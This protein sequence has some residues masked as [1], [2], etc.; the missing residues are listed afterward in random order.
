M[1]DARHSPLRNELREATADTH[2]RLERR[3]LLLAPNLDLPAYKRVLQAYYGFYH[4]L[5]QRLTPVANTIP[6]LDWPHRAKTP[7]LC[8]DLAVVAPEQAPVVLAACGH[9]PTVDHAAQVLG[10][11][12]VLEGATLGGQVLCRHV[13]TRTGLSPHRGLAFLHSYGNATGRRW[14]DFVN[15]LNAFETSANTERQRLTAA[16]ENTFRTFE[17]WL[18]LRECLR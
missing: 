5:E 14:R 9:L 15:C 12:Y 8:R 1:E 11:L 16:A 6:G 2:R 18:E 17:N 10:C 7:W 13:A 4:P 3:L